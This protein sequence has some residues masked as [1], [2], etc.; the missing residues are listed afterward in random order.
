[1]TPTKIEIA[2]YPDHLE[3]VAHDAGEVTVSEGRDV[4]IEIQQPML[5]ALMETVA[6]AD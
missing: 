6:S 5:D 1:M 3:I 4:I 2:W